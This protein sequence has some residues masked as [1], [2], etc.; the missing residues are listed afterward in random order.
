[1]EDH[2]VDRPGV[3]A[4]QCVKLTGPNSSIGLIHLRSRTQSQAR[5]G[6]RKDTKFPCVI[7]SSG[8]RYQVSGVSVF[9]SLIPDPCH[10]GPR[11]E[12]LAA[13]YSPTCDHAVPSALRVFTAEF[14]MGSGGSP[15]AL[16]TR[17]SER[18]WTPMASSYRPSA[19][20]RQPNA[21]S[22]SLRAFHKE[23]E[24]GAACGDLAAESSHKS[25]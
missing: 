4:Q 23:R 21:E 25:D 16:A 22:R 3:E 24:L 8:I 7:Q 19:F 20:S 6:R 9:S 15:L 12:G 5:G 10:L 13:T 18:G 11:C 17:P 14:G 1:M 2:H